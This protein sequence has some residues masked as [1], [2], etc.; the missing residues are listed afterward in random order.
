MMPG[1]YWETFVLRNNLCTS[2]SSNACGS[3]GL[4][5]PGEQEGDGYVGTTIFYRPEIEDPASQLYASG[6]VYSQNLNV[7][8]PG[9]SETTPTA[10]LVAVDKCNRTLPNGNQIECETG[11]F[12]LGADEQQKLFST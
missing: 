2:D 12:S 11:L 5:K 8:S 1:S 3:G 6:E 4:W 7:E 9:Q 10:S